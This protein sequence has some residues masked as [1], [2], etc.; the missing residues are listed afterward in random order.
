MTGVAAI[1]PG[2]EAV[3][4]ADPPLVWL[5][6]GAVLGLAGILWRLLQVAALL[7]VGLFVWIAA[8]QGLPVLE[9]ALSEFLAQSL[10][11]HARL[12]LGA[13]L[14]AVFGA[15]FLRL[16]RGPSRFGGGP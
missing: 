5:L 6:A 14:G 1:V 4:T 3:L 8:H 9:Q 16:V 10:M 12:V 7:T 2:L 15:S 13:A 11:P